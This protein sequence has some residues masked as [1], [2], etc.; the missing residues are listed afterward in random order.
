[1]NELRNMDEDWVIPKGKEDLNNLQYLRL[2][3][4]ELQGRP[5]GASGPK[6]E[7]EQQTGQTERYSR[8]EGWST[9][10]DKSNQNIKPGRMLKQSELQG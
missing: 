8:S 4:V 7:T 10:K 6:V 9:P 5:K 3:Q 2:I 1:M